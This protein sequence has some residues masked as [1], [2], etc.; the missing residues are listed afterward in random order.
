MK[1]LKRTFKEYKVEAEVGYTIT[2][3]ASSEENAEEAAQDIPY[4][5]LDD[6]GEILQIQVNRSETDD[7]PLVQ[8]TIEWD[9]RR[10]ETFDAHT[11]KRIEACIED[12]VELI[13]SER[14]N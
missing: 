9:E 6:M 14:R 5:E 7:L 3:T 1:E 4:N 8:I 13:T 2:I 12:L 10:I 11:T